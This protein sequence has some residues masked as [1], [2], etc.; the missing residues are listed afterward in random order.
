MIHFKRLED[1]RKIDLAV[2]TRI[3]AG[4]N[5]PELTGKLF[6]VTGISEVRWD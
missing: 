2:L 5:L 6:G 3:T 4:T 1:G